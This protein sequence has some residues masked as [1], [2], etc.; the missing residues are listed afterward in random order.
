[1]FGECVV[2]KSIPPT[3]E[4]EEIE[5]LDP[6][7]DLFSLS[8]PSINYTN[9]ITKMFFLETVDTKLVSNVI[10]F[11]I[12]FPVLPNTTAGI[13][14]PHGSSKEIDFPRILIRKP[15]EAYVCKRPYKGFMADAHGLH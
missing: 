13:L 12:A 2:K 1:M 8:F 7:W 14:V 11:M 10:N 3:M 9:L 5:S 15:N 4:K 6:S